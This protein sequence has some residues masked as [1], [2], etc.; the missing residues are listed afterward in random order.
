MSR[1]TLFI[2]ITVLTLI[3][4]IIVLSS[5]SGTELA[6]IIPAAYVAGMY[7]WLTAYAAQKKR[8]EKFRA[9]KHYPHHTEVYDAKSYDEVT[10]ADDGRTDE[11]K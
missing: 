1:K 9:E 7:L 6:V 2:F 10:A 8:K 4:E 3:A 11:I 5:G